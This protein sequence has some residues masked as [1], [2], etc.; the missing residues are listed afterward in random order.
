MPTIFVSDAIAEERLLLGARPVSGGHASERWKALSALYQTSFTRCGFKL[1]H[2]VRPE[3]Y[4]TEWA[5]H[6]VGVD[7]GDWHLAVKPIEHLRPF[8]GIPNVFVCDWTF[9]TVSASRLG[10]FPFFDQVHLLGLADAVLCCTELTANTLRGAG[11]DRVVSLPPYVPSVRHVRTASSSGQTRFLCVVETGQL[12]LVIEGFSQAASRRDDLHMTFYQRGNDPPSETRRRLADVASLR[13]VSLVLQG[14]PVDLEGLLATADFF[15]RPTWF[16][17]LNLAVIKAMQAGV[18]VLATA[19]GSSL[20]P[21]ATVP[22]AAQ[23]E[24]LDWTNEPIG[25]YMALS[26]DRP[27]VDSLCDAILAAADCSEEEKSRMAEAGR[28]AAE[29]EFGLPAFQA[30]LTR[31]EALLP[32]YTR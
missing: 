12:D 9:P 17:G 19:G 28:Q 13:N 2:L 16:E 24:V 21:E 14:N 22:I 30:G 29:R 4:Q 5:R 18:P 15:V 32:R 20:A 10:G 8:H 11:L 25:R 26:I 3:I 1:R 23:T 31:L 27:T 7:T 6:A